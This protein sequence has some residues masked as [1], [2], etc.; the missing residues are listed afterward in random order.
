MLCL[1]EKL[2]ALSHKLDIM[3]KELILTKL[4]YGYLYY[5]FNSK[6]V[7]VPLKCDCMI[8]NTIFI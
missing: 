2:R 3:S 4:F 1:F 7:F 5:H 8:N 6:D